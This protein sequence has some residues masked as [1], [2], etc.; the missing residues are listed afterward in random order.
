MSPEALMRPEGAV[1]VRVMYSNARGRQAQ[2]LHFVCAAQHEVRTQTQ[3][4]QENFRF[5]LQQATGVV[6]G[7]VLQVQALDVCRNTLEHHF[8]FNAMSA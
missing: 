1:R 3:V 8:G 2:H 7:Y 6:L 4:A 5:K